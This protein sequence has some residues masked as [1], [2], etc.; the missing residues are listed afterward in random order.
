MLEYARSQGSLCIKSEDID[1]EWD[2]LE[3]KD[4]ADLNEWKS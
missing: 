3:N 4:L 1:M 2:I